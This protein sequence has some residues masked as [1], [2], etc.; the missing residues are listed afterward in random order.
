MK[1]I[2]RQ[3]KVPKFP[4]VCLTGS[5]KDME[6]P[7]EIAMLTAVDQIFSLKKAKVRIRDQKATIGRETT[8]K[9]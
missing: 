3:A 4:R 2:A 8:R 5:P 9:T 6:E 1:Q 7:S